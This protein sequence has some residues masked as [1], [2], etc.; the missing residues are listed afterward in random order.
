M[1][2]C[3]CERDDIQMVEVCVCERVCESKLYISES[4]LEK[5]LVLEKV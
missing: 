5:T 4:F 1:C 3:V 2:V